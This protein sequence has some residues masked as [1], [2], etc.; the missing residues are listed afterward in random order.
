MR[1]LPTWI[2]PQCKVIAKVPGV[3]EELLCSSINLER[4][5]LPIGL[6]QVKL[7]SPR[8]LSDLSAYNVSECSDSSEIGLA[9]YKFDTQ[10]SLNGGKPLTASDLPGPVLCLGASAYYFPILS[11]L[12]KSVLS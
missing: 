6:Y 9:R 10:F 3:G 2:N 11:S 4:G 8:G 12:N 7:A 1:W 5:L